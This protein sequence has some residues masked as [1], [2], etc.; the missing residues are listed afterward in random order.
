VVELLDGLISAESAVSALVLSSSA[1]AFGVSDELVA[2]DSDRRVWEVSS[3]SL[4]EEALVDGSS[5]MF[6]IIV[7]DVV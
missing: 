2:E 4:T 5:E 1:K 3:C 6:V 7:G